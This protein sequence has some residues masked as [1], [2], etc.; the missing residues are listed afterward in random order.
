[1]VELIIWLNLRGID[2]EF[3]HWGPAQTQIVFSHGSGAFCC[4][5]ESVILD[6]PE[7]LAEIK[8]IVM[9]HMGWKTND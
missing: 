5:Y 3:S 8:D 1:M 9:Q 6:R 7:V 4:S 2:V